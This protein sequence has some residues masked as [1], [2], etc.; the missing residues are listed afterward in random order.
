MTARI[1]LDA[2]QALAERL[3][4]DTHPRAGDPQR[5][6]RPSRRLHHPGVP[7]GARS[8]VWLACTAS[9]EVADSALL[10]T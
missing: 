5:L 7:D 8:K 3:V 9:N 6:P 10:R 4:D 1:D 2:R